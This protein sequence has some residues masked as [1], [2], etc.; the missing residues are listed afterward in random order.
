MFLEVRVDRQTRTL[1]RDLLD[2]AAD[3]LSA[4]LVDPWSPCYQFLAFK[5]G[6]AICGRQRLRDRLPALHCDLL[7]LAFLADD[8][9]ASVADALALQGSGPRY[10]RISAATW[11]TICL[12]MPVTVIS[13]GFGTAIV[14]PWGS[15]RR[16]HG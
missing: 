9:L 5:N 3:A 6:A 8:L 12:S 14:M 1:A 16:R 13:V 7:L 2:L 4:T 10:S 11:P 15:H